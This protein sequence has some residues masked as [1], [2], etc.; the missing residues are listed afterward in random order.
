VY[1]YFS[2]R[3]DLL[4]AVC[5][6]A[7]PQWTGLI[8]KA[9]VGAS[10]PEAVVRTFVT[11]QLDRVRSGDHRL[12]QAVAGSELSAE[13]RARLHSLHA[14]V[15]RPLEQALRQ[16]GHRR[17]A[18]IAALLQGLVR[19]A[20]ELIEAGQPANQVSQDTVRVALEGVR[21]S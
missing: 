2:C 9:L 19:S 15:R 7:M 1:E 14:N 8:E 5:E 4:V 3:E 20:T 17:P 10:S 21:G 6:D 11:T 12:A 18:V 16:L 13:T